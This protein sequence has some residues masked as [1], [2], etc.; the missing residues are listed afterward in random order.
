MEAYGPILRRGDTVQAA[1][2]LQR[3]DACDMGIHV[4]GGRRVPRA[5]NHGGAAALTR[6]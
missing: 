6:T 1:A 3:R 5:A 2:W 4:S